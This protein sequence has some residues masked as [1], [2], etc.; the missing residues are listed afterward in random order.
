MSSNGNLN[1]NEKEAHELAEIQ[2]N[3]GN[4]AFKSKVI[5]I[6]TLIFFN[7]FRNMIRLLNTII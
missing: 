1:L 6:I 5:I 3:L 4:E 7:L 2:K